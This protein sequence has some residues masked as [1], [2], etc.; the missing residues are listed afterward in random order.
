MATPFC[1]PEPLEVVDTEPVPDPW[2][3]WF[4]DHPIETSLMAIGSIALVGY[5][6]YS[7]GK[8]KP[9]STSNAKPTSKTTKS[10]SSKK[11]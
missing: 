8:P 4:V 9:I 1:S 7:S 11:R 10:A 5:V 2:Y 3:K 6:A